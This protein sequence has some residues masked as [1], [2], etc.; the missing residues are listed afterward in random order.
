MKL[1]CGLFGHNWHR[2][3]QEQCPVDY[4]VCIRCRK[5]RHEC[6]SPIM[7]CYVPPRAI[8]WGVGRQRFFKALAAL[9]AR[10]SVGT[11]P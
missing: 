5:I 4:F 6:T 8:V 11:K 9:R 7:H 1:L 10:V 3:Q 2:F